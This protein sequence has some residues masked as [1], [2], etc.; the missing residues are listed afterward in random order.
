MPPKTP[1]SLPLIGIWWD[2]GQTLAAQGQPP[3]E[4]STVIAG[5]FDS[6]LAHV[7][8]WKDV[9]ARF[10]KSPREEY[11]TVPRGRVVLSK[12]TG[13]SVIYHGSATT[14]ERL[15]AIAAEFQLVVWKAAIDPHYQI[16]DAADELFDDD[17]W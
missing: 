6:D 17:D 7:D 16:G 9:A 15:Q 1:P 5:Y 8:Q 10:G 12:R 4:R 2:N 14:P 3:A 13:E 11:F